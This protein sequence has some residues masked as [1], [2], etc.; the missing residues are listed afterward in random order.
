M[1]KLKPEFL[2]KNGRAEFVVLTAED[3]ESFK[4]MIEDAQDYML[5]QKARAQNGNAPG[6]PVADVKRRL[7][8]SQRRKSKA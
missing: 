8:T 2:K 6:V 7:A 1:L 4:Q 3:Y 5:I